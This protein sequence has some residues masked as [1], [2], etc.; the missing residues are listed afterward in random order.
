[1][2][3]TVANV[4]AAQP[5]ATG[6]VLRAPVGTA[7]PTSAT[8]TPNI[9]FTDLGYI[10]EDGITESHARSSD[11]KKAFGGTVVKVLQT[12][13]S[14]TIKVVFLESV[15]AEVLKAV[16]GDANVTT[17]GSDI[18]VKKNK[19]LL[20]HSSWIFDTLD[21]DGS[22]R[23]VVPD[24]QVTEVG[25]IQKVNTEVIMYEVTIECFEDSAGTPV[26]E[27]INKPASV[28]APTVVSLSPSSVGVAGGALVIVNGSK[29]TGATGVT[30]GGTAATAFIVESPSR[31]IF[32]APAKSAGSYPVV[33]TNAT[34]PSNNTVSLTYA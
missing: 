33:V 24:G 6:T 17:S 11:K 1:M 9:A 7:L 29:F 18:T 8:A 27:Y 23:T 16:W 5:K 4:Y 32:T 19:D 25:D 22:I 31:L 13:Y 28:G 21:G 20:P 34:G 3:S 14:A 26:Y 30:V 12:D 10:G 2:A 15:N